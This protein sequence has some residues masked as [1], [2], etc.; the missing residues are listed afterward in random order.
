M[1]Q[2]LAAVAI[3]SLLL[4]P[5]SAA[6]ADGSLSYWGWQ[7][8]SGKALG[9]PASTTWGPG[10]LD[11][12]VRGTDNRLWHKWYTA[13]AWLGWVSLGAPPGGLAS[14]PGAV[15]WSP[16]R[17]D[18]FARGKDGQL[19]HKWY[20]AGW[21]GWQP[22]G[23]FLVGAPAV[24]SWSSGRLDIF[25][26]GTDNR[27]WHKWYQ[28]GWSSWQPLGGVLTSAPAAVSWG[29]GRIDVVVA[30]VGGAA[31]HTFYAGGWHRFDF[32]GGHL[33]G[34]PA[35]SS[36]A[37]GGLDVFARGTDNNLYHQWYTA[38]W[39]GWQFALGGPLTSGPGAVSWGLNRVDVFA[40]R[41]GG[42]IYHAFGAPAPP[43]PSIGARPAFYT[44]QA[45]G[46]ARTAG[47]RVI[48]LTFDDGPGPYTPQV[49]A[50]LKQY[51]VAA[52]FFEVGEEVAVYP[53]YARTVA[54]AGY[55]VENHT[56]SHVNLATTPVSQFPVQID[57]TQN[58]IRAVTGL[59][60]TCVR[61][62]YD[63]WNSTVLSQIAQRGLATMSYSID[64]R[65]WSLPG[66]QVIVDR[67]V[68]AAVAGGVVDLHDAGG[69]RDQT[70]AALPQ[71][72]TN[73][74]AQGYTFG[75]I[76]GGRQS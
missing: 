47:Q 43:A 63:A 48:A 50:I 34:A 2:L 41:T 66:V 42:Q 31:W 58:E 40:T 70:V 54:A 18:V 71:I 33:V 68:G 5:S 74:E 62:P 61:P 57:Q 65:D 30:G 76:C 24:A 10:R 17:I 11:V 46:G 6:R 52:T 51:R 36:W 3:L 14:D 75:P 16:G 35:I 1:A 7:P 12:F 69:P 19:W 32:L 67:V 26:R 60:P 9:S 13:G 53:Q 73:L 29:P 8:L 39:S 27:L 25:V 56:W 28:G 49:L 21:S 55:P 38:R 64:P 72:I 45:P 44:Y 20:A 15:S 23:G 22:L 59:T 4:I 37:A